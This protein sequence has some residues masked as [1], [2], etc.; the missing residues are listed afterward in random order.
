MVAVT[1]VATT[2]AVS[3][4]SLSRPSDIG[5]KP[6]WSAKV[7]SSGE[8]SPSGPIKINTL[9]PFFSNLPRYSRSPRAE[10]QWA[11]NFSPSN[12]IETTSRTGVIS[13]NTG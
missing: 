6:F 7:I 2:A 10:L 11:I 3:V 5:L 12:G 13:C 4:R 8:K 1:T 9:P